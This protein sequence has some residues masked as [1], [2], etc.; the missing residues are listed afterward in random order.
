MCDQG[1]EVRG[2][3]AIVLYFGGTVSSEYFEPVFG[4]TDRWLRYCTCIAKTVGPRFGQ[5]RLTDGAMGLL[6]P[7]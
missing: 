3:S 7:S 5:D 1:P 6:R 4:V 2:L